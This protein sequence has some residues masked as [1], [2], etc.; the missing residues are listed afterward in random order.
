M[1]SCYSKPVV[2]KTCSTIVV[3]FGTSTNQFELPWPA[4]DIGVITSYDEGSSTLGAADTTCSYTCLK[5]QMLW[6]VKLLPPPPLLTQYRLWR[7]TFLN[8]IFSVIVHEP[9]TNI[10]NLTTTWRE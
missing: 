7:R 10:L 2:N 3:K 5:Y 1:C 8:W 9:D 6:A 4:P